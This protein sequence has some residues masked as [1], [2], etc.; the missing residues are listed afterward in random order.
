MILPIYTY[1]QPVLREEAEEVDVD[2]PEVKQQLETLLPDMFETL[3]HADGVGLAAPQ[4]GLP[5]RLVVVDLSAYADED[6]AFADYK[7]VFINPDIYEESREE[8]SM[9]E[10]CLSLPGIHENV[11]RPVS[12]RIRYLDEHFQ[13]HDEELSGFPARVIQHECDHLDGTMFI[14]HL[15]G[16]RKQM[17]KGKLS[18]LLK[19]KI[20]AGY[21]VKQLPRKA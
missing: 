10:G 19:G 11:K 15:A 7:K 4:V 3:D 1:G 16:L 6:P 8:C 18:A 20:Q 21:K 9:G 2:S 5:I 13:V 14:D 17:I 12:V